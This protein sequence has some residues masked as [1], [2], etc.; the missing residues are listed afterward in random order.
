MAAAV[1]K[2][3][4][5]MWKLLVTCLILIAL[6]PS[7]ATAKDYFSMKDYAAGRAPHVSSAVDG[8]NDDGRVWIA[9]KTINCSGIRLVVW[10]EVKDITDYYATSEHLWNDTFPRVQGKFVYDDAT[11]KTSLEG[12]QCKDA[13]SQ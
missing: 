12:R 11:G 8:T 3:E 10:R 4:A 5:K 13:S 7:P 6:L 2:T 9:L 1:V